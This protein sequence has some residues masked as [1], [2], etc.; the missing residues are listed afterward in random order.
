MEKQVL[1]RVLMIV[2]GTALF[3]LG[4][5]L[6]PDGILGFLLI[7]VA[8]SLIIIGLTLKGIIHLLV[9]IL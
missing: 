5:I 1:I 8:L 7:T 9:N 6:E 3:M 2:L 4:L